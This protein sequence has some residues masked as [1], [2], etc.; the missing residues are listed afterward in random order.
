MTYR[1]RL[2]HSRRSGY[3]CE[4]CNRKPGPVE[5][6]RPPY[7]TFSLEHEVRPGDWRCFEVYGANMSA[8]ELWA[9]ASI[10]ALQYR[11]EVRP[12]F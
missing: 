3:G 8:A 11:V 6:I 5:C 9:R 12:C 2:M 4:C 7:S 1:N 10:I